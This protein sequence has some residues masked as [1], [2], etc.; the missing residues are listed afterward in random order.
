MTGQSAVSKAQTSS[1]GAL[2]VAVVKLL[3]RL[4][5]LG[6]LG[7]ALEWLLEASHASSRMHKILHSINTPKVHL[8]AI[9]MVL[10]GHIAEHLHQ[11]EENHHQEA[12]LHELRMEVQ[13]LRKGA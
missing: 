12:H 5:Y 1:L 6:L 4:R 13:K 7:Y 3:A 9:S 8:L 10:A 2:W 11:E